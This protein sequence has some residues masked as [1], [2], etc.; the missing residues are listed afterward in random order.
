M[1]RLL[2]LLTLLALPLFAIA[3]GGDSTD[4]S[5]PS[6]V[7][8]S[9]ADKVQE[10][11]SFKFEFSATFDIPE[12][13]G[14]DSEDDDFGS[15]FGGS[16]SM[17]GDGQFD[18]ANNRSHIRMNVFFIAVEMIQDGDQCYVRSNFSGELWEREDDCNG[19]LTSGDLGFAEDPTTMLNDL[20]DVADDIEEVGTETIRG[21]ETRHYRVM[22]SDPEFTEATGQESMPFDIWVDKDGRPAKLLMELAVDEAGELFGAGDEGGAASMTIE[23][24]FF[25]WGEPVDIQV[26]S[27]DEIGDGTFPGLGDSGTGDEEFEWPFDEEEE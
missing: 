6:E 5:S 8:S 20:R 3:C 25:D 10:E 15:F 1:S 11:D 12:L 19:A 13:E 17:D 26:P 16:L 18:I 21:V 4:D 2:L 24:S 27:E 9:V 7:L 22:I 23:F 14:E